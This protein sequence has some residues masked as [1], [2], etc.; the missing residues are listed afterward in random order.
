MG[1]QFM[2]HLLPSDASRLTP[3]VYFLTNPQESANGI[4]API[5]GQVLQVQLFVDSVL[6]QTESG[7]NSQ[8]LSLKTDL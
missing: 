3:G 6:K 2:S 4:F 8:Q 5:S 1:D 7:S